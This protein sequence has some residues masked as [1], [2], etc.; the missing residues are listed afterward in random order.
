M[1]GR[2]SAPT[3]ERLDIIYS[4]AGDDLSVA[5]NSATASAAGTLNLMRG[6]DNVVSKLAKILSLG[7]I[8][9]RL[10]TTS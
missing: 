7:V 4:V 10:P 6:G 5:A 9:P 8:I 2:E 1:M 3:G